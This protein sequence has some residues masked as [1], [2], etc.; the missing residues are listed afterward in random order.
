MIKPGTLYKRF[1]LHNKKECL[2]LIKRYEHKETLYYHSET[3]MFG[4]NTGSLRFC[5]S[6]ELEPNKNLVK[7]NG[8][9]YTCLFYYDANVAGD[10]SLTETL[11]LVY[12]NEDE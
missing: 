9:T 8:K 10:A 11:Y 3:W 6:D 12:D 4:D 5:E 2:D 7:I 1:W